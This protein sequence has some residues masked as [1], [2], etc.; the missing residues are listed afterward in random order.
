MHNGTSFPAHFPWHILQKCPYD[1]VSLSYDI[2]CKYMKGFLRLAHIVLDC[3]NFHMLCQKLLKK[4]VLVLSDI[5]LLQ[6]RSVSIYHS[7]LLRSGTLY[8]NHNSVFF[9]N[10]TSQ[11]F[12]T[13]GKINCLWTNHIQYL[14]VEGFQ[15]SKYGDKQIIPIN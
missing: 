9:L 3:C 10:S 15:I 7:R 6:H 11:S 4:R 8:H 13:L 2:H 5:S 1:K 14:Q 12:H